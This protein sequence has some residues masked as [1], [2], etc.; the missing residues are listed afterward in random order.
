MIGLILRIHVVGLRLLIDVVRVV[1]KDETMSS[2]YDRRS[3]QVQRGA[4][5]RWSD[6]VFLSVGSREG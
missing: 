4:Y 1:R 2:R 6:I 5:L 3:R